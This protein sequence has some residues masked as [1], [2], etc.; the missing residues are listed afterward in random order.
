MFIVWLRMFT[1]NLKLVCDT[2]SCLNIYPSIL[3]IIGDMLEGA[4]RRQNA[5]SGSVQTKCIQYK[6]QYKDSERFN[7]HTAYNS[8]FYV[9]RIVLSTSASTVPD[10]SET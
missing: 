9:F 6:I 2:R 10:G 8:V 3:R 1:H 5:I 4:D 7:R